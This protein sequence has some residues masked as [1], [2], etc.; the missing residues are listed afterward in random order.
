M[1]TTEGLC[2]STKAVKSGKLLAWAR[3]TAVAPRAST[4]QANQFFMI[5]LDS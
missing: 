4:I 1:F 2:F 3:E 5:D